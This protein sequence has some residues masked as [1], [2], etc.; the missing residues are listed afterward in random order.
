MAS[1][2]FLTAL[3]TIE[4]SNNDLALGKAGERGAYQ[5]KAITWKQHTN[6]DFTIYAHDR[7]VS[8]QVAYMHLSWLKKSF[9]NSAGRVPEPRDFYIM[10]RV[11]YAGYRSRGFIITNCETSLQKDAWRFMNI[12]KQQMEKN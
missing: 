11:G 12:Y 3:A 8:S 9:V 6:I 7:Q 10:W 5:I 4:S 1:D 2:Q